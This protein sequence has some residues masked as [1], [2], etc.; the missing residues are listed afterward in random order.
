MTCTV[1]RSNVGIELHEGRRPQKL[2][3]DLSYQP[4]RK[5]SKILKRIFSG[6]LVK[7]KRVN[8]LTRFQEVNKN[9]IGDVTAPATPTLAALGKLLTNLNQTGQTLALP[10]A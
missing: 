1:Q 7:S 8:T 4:Y 2:N 5:Q 9:E 3:Q 6:L 10:V